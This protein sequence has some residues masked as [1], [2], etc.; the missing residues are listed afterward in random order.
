MRSRYLA[1]PL[2][3]LLSALPPVTTFA[4]SGP[5]VLVRVGIHEGYSRIAFNF[6][7]WT[8]YHV[9]QQGQ[10]VVVQFAG[11]VTIGPATPCRAMSSRSPVAPAKRTSSWSQ[12]QP[13]ATGGSAMSW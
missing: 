4:D 6:A 11:N 13:C 9:T 12:E 10:H 2:A 5:T 1:W 8:D 3:A 7:S